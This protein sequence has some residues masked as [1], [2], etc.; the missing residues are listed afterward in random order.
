MRLSKNFGVLTFGNIFGQKLDYRNKLIS[1]TDND[2]EN[3]PECTGDN[4]PEFETVIGTHGLNKKSSWL[5]TL[6]F[7]HCTEPVH[8]TRSHCYSVH[9]RF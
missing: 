5:H 4:V 9:F 6:L 1:G 3:V 7:S 2:T 8:I